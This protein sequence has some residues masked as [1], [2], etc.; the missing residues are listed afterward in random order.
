MY[1]CACFW[2]DLSRVDTLIHQQNVFVFCL[3]PLRDQLTNQQHHYTEHFV[4]AVLVCIFPPLL[5][6]SLQMTL[7]GY[8]WPILRMKLLTT[9]AIC[10][11]HPYPRAH[12]IG[13]RG[14]FSESEPHLV[15]DTRTRAHERLS[16][17]NHC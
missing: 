1:L 17:K 15:R 6:P 8:L 10:I 12:C 11:G 9:E 4:A 5:I 3:S 13:A 7:T 14:P 16:Y 2:S